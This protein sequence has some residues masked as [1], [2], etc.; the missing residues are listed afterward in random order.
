MPPARRTR[1]LATGL[2]AV[3]ASELA[4]AAVTATGLIRV[5][6]VSIPTT[7]G[8]R[9]SIMRTWQLSQLCAA[10]GNRLR[11]QVADQLGGSSV[12]VRAGAMSPPGPGANTV[13]AG[14][15]MRAGRPG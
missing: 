7:P 4:I 5:I 9:S 14:G 13:R 3:V 1:L 8:A 10:E 6:W 11:D 15:A 2:L 12:F